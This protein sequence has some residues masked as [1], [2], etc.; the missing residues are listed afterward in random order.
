MPVVYSCREMWQLIQALGSQ[1]ADGVRRP[2]VDEILWRIWWVREV[3]ESR[4]VGLNEWTELTHK[5]EKSGR[6]GRRVGSLKLKEKLLGRRQW[7]SM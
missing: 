2:E 3:Q 5:R 7:S 4:K 1:L 6:G